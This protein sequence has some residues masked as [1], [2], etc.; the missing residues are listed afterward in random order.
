MAPKKY[1]RRGKDEK[2]ILFKGGI[3]S[4]GGPKCSNRTCAGWGEGSRVLGDGVIRVQTIQI[5]RYI[6]K[7]SIYLHTLE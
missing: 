1:I 7:Y 2:S 3:F 6:W 4:G 5:A